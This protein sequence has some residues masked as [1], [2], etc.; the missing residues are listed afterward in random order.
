VR[1]PATAVSPRPAARFAAKDAV[2]K[3]VA[4][5]L[6]APSDD[7]SSPSSRGGTPHVRGNGKATELADRRGIGKVAISVSHGAGIPTAVALASS[8]LW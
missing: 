6:A 1:E 2:I 5:V 4:P 7:R 8:A 3:L